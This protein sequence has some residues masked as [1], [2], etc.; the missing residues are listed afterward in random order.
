MNEAEQY[1][2]IKAYDFAALVFSP[3]S[4]EN[5]PDILP[6]DGY[7]GFFLLARYA[8]I[9]LNSLLE[10]TQERAVYECYPSLA[11]SFLES[12]TSFA[13]SNAFLR[14]EPYTC[15][16]VDLLKRVF[17]VPVESV[18]DFRPE[19]EIL[20]QRI[21]STRDVKSRIRSMDI[22]L[23]KKWC[24]LLRI[25]LILYPEDPASQICPDY[26]N[27]LR[28][29]KKRGIPLPYILWLENSIRFQELERTNSVEKMIF[30]AESWENQSRFF[31]DFHNPYEFSYLVLDHLYEKG[32]FQKGLGWLN[33]LR[34]KSR[35]DLPLIKWEIRFLRESQQISKAKALCE[36]ALNRHPRDDD[37]YCFAS[38][39]SFLEGNFDQAREE[40]QSAVIYGENKASNHVALAYSALYQDDLEVANSAFSTALF[41]DE[42]NLDARRGS[43]KTFFLMGKSFEALCCLQSIFRKYP[44]SVE[45][46][47]DLADMYFSCGYMKEASLYAKKCLNMDGNYVSAFILLGMLDSREARDERAVQWFDRA[48][49][50]DPSNPIALNELAYIQHINGNDDVCLELLEKAVNAAPDFPDAICS[51]GVVYFYQSRF[52]EALAFFDRTLFLDPYHIGA[53][54][55]KG[56]LYL[57]QGE[58]KEALIWFDKAL[59]EDPLFPEAIYGKV[60]AYRSLGLEEDAFEWH[61]KIKDTGAPGDLF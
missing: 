1:E 9:R 40:G 55:G 37:L 20:I 58:A 41:L 51:L 57:A 3:K 32:E 23:A 27:D 11:R 28:I 43:A 4:V 7:Y 39:L 2:Y 24:H 56:N 12:G 31:P 18:R 36:E 54:V 30:L 61:E 15:L 42:D 10:T 47:Y 50:L 19:A 25:F 60:S 8:G 45:I 35:D 33:I 44:D 48:L 5:W 16:I 49:E 46:C 34:R 26:Q 52:E 14:T 6:K 13:P 59:E 53:F 29:S 21:E 22:L 38:N 17:D